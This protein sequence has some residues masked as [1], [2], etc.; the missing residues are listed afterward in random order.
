MS[1][2]CHPPDDPPGRG[3]SREEGISGRAVEARPET[4]FE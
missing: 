4:Y 3:K 2:G 1:G